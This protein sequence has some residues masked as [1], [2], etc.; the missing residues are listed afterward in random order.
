[1]GGGD[2]GYYAPSYMNDVTSGCDNRSDVTL[3]G[4]NKVILICT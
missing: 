1:M 3:N 4:K 2:E